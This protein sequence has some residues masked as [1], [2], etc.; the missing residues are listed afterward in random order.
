M[1]FSANSICE[2]IPRCSNTNIQDKRR[3][4]CRQSFCLA[5]RSLLSEAVVQVSVDM[6]CVVIVSR[7]RCQ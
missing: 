4:E 1:N 6:R 3:S 5:E 7:Q 2:Y